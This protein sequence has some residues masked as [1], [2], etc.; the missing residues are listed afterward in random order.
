MVEQS[1]S[2]HAGDDMQFLVFEYTRDE[3]DNELLS[4]KTVPEDITTRAA[5]IEWLPILNGAYKGTKYLIV[6]AKSWDIAVL[7]EKPVK[8][9]AEWVEEPPSCG[10]EV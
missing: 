4:E 9:F 6:E 1:K 5:V 8:T 10:G 7:K 3:Y 2:A